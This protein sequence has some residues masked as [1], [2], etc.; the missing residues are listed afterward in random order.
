MHIQWEMF[1]AHEPQSHTKIVVHL[2]LFRLPICP[3]GA[4]SPP[5]QPN[6]S[7]YVDSSMSSFQMTFCS[8]HFKHFPCLQSNLCKSTFPLKFFGK[9]QGNSAFMY[10]RKKVLIS[11]GV[12]K[13]TATC[14]GVI[15]WLPELSPLMLHCSSL[16]TYLFQFFFKGG[17]KVPT[18]I[19]HTWHSK[20][21]VRSTATCGRQNGKTEKNASKK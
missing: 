4:P 15:F 9:V 3:D 13:W 10:A 5:R 12:L 2:Q 7:S 21:G 19:G 17:L 16:I 6:R 8:Y 20:K 14:S 11:T 1:T 18:A